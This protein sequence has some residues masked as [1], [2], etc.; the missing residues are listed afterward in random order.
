MGLPKHD[1]QHR[2]SP[3]Q[4]P[5]DIPT[6]IMAACC[7]GTREAHR[8]GHLSLLQAAAPPLLPRLVLHFV[9][10]SPLAEATMATTS[11]TWSIPGTAGMPGASGAQVR[12]VLGVLRISTRVSPNLSLADAT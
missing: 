11:F 2:C 6:D 8:R 4:R 7:H 1:S 9:V 12:Y 10:E 3:I 5:T